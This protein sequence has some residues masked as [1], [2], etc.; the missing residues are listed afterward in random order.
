MP[1]QFTNDYFNNSY[2]DICNSIERM[3]FERV[4]TSQW[5]KMNNLI[6]QFE[7]TK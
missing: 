4:N 6:K 3:Q 7:Y 5:P 2:I 1:T